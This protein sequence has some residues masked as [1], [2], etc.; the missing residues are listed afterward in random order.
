MLISA[1]MYTIQSQRY[2]D[3]V[4]KLKVGTLNNLG[5]KNGG[6]KY[7]L[8]LHRKAIE[9]YDAKK[10]E[11]DKEKDKDKSKDK[12]KDKDKF[13]K[14]R[15]DPVF[16]KCVD[17]V[18]SEVSVGGSAKKP[19][20]HDIFAVQLVMLPYTGFLAAKKYYRRHFS[21]AQLTEDELWEMAMERVGGRVWDSLEEP[22]QAE[23]VKTQVWKPDV[24]QAWIEARQKEEQEAIKKMAKKF[25]KRGYEDYSDEEYVE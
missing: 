8:D 2:Q 9:R 7:T 24:Y 10:A 12:G 25:K 14:M 19:T 20:V 18:I 13:S 21:G 4:K 1:L 15:T 5:P 17:E 3:V 11:Q 22:Q 16:E 6:S 23:L